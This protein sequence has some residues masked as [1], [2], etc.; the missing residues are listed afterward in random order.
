M[1]ALRMVLIRAGLSGFSRLPF[2]W[3]QALGAFFG[4]LAWW[5]GGRSRQVTEANLAVAFPEQTPQQRRAL[6]HRSLA[7]T[8]RTVAEIAYM[9]ERPV[10]QCLSLIREVDG[11]HWVDEAREAGTG[12]LLLAPHL[13]N[14]ELT[15]LY[16]A[17]HFSMAAL[18]S[19]PNLPEMEAYMS[20]VRGRSGSELV[21]ADRRGVLRLFTLLRNGGVV[22]IL[23][24]QNPQPEGGEFAPFFGI[25]ILTMKL[26]SRLV[27]K[28]GAR[29]LITWAERLPG[30]QGFRLL[31]RPVDERVYSEDLA[32]SVAG[33][34]ASVEQAVRTAP[35]QYQWEYKRFKRRPAGQPHVY[36]KGRVC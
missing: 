19:P 18:Y 17:E 13:G 34:N 22:G 14:W 28:T 5:F 36:D 1:K 25:E 12:L 33:V 15:G 23:P 6:A 4:R 26:A 31:I 21:R 11:Q 30:G 2:A 9:W 24:D 16:F 10:P 29:G 3:G 27:N 20:R 8:G 7:E 35:A 32:T